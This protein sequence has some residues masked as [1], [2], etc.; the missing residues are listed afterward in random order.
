MIPA[1]L[2][3]A[4]ERDVYCPDLPGFGKSSKPARALNVAELSGALTA[5]LQTSGIERATLVGHSFGCQIAAEFALENPEKLERLVLA[6]P[7]GDPRV[8]SL[9]RYLGRLALD[10]AREPLSLAPL[11]VRDYLKA[12]LVRGFR[13]FQFA[14][15]DRIED[16][17]PRIATPSLVVRG[18][19]D[20]IVSPDWAA[21]AA[22][23]LP[24]A[25]LATIES[26]AHAMNYS[27]PRKF[28]RIIREFINRETF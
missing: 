6:A 26:A 17:L 10:A 9:F 18:L 7:S 25:E 28:A 3:L 23:L 8:N 13:T 1:A 4:R 21:R 19:R 5:F 16:K 12:G 2:E 24:N 20:P 27:S 22:R 14:V 15:R 11:A